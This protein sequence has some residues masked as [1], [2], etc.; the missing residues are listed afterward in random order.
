MLELFEE[1]ERRLQGQERCIL[2][3]VIN[4][5]GSVPRGAGAMML[6]NETGRCWGTIGGGPVEFKATQLSQELVE[7]KQTKIEHFDQSIKSNAMCG[8][9]YDVLMLY[10][11]FKN[12]ELQEAMVQI[13]E[14]AKQSKL[15]QL[16]FPLEGGVPL[17]GALDKIL[18]NLVELEGQAYYVQT[19]NN[20]GMVYVF[21]GGHVA[22]ELVPVLAHLDF[23]CVV[24]DD[25]EEFANVQKFP[26]AVQ[27][28]AVDY[29]QL[30]KYVTINSQDYIL[31]MTRGHICDAQVERFALK[32]SAKYIGLMGSKTKKTLIRAKLQAEGF[33]L[34][35]LERVIIP[36]GLDIGS[37][38]P[39]EIAISIAAQL[40]QERAKGST[41]INKYRE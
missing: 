38:T 14:Q 36:V 16:L 6:V 7:L 20:D 28:F 13:L 5:S 27:V 2:D 8:G 21:G 35:Q 25:R 39:A 31:I 41:G 12:Q 10:L 19:F 18:P 15:F 34:E 9:A 32:S 26:Q 11:D 33:T 29:E 17:L 4:S 3:I 37:E 1:L 22:Q 40:I 30:E 23:R 24:M